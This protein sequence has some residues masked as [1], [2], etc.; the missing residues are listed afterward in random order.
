MNARI[1]VVFVLLTFIAFAAWWRSRASA[2]AGSRDLPAGLDA[3]RW[4]SGGG[5]LVL[6][7]PWCASC[8][9]AADLLGSLG[10]QDVVRVDV[11]VEPE[12]ARRA[13]ARQAPTALRVD[14]SG[15]VVS[16]LEGVAAIR[17]FVM[18]ERAATA[19]R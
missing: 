10:A 6:S 4:L 18:A 2:R 7:T 9:P 12:L 19:V 13:D 5:W 11:T 14:T 1:A 8:G 15:V 16:R 3:A 17:E